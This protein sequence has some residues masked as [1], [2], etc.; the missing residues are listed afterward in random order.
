[1]SSLPEREKAPDGGAKRA[2]ARR[3][4][5]PV[6]VSATHH[7]KYARLAGGPYFEPV[8]L[9]ARAYLAAAVADPRAGEGVYWAL[10]C[11]PATTRWRLSAVTMRIT[12]ALV[13]SKPRPG[14]TGVQALMLV[15][16]STL[17]EGFGDRQAARDLLPGVDIVDSDYYDAGPDQALIRGPWAELVTALANPV[18]ATAARQIAG[19][20]MAG[21]RTLHWRGHNRLLAADALDE[22]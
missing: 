4:P 17:E 3:A 15:E 12:D 20:I 11:L 14:Q 10:S 2:G 8:V 9:T 13:I 18:V 7:H 5:G 16:Q 22:R 6:P 21:G 19:R 1:V